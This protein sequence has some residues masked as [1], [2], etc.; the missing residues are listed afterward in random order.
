MFTRRFYFQ[1][2]RE[3]M[4]THPGHLASVLVEYLI[5]FW[6]G[7]RFRN[8]G[9]LLPSLC[10]S[11]CWRTDFDDHG[12]PP[13]PLASSLAYRVSRAVNVAC[14]SANPSTDFLRIR[15]LLFLG[16]LVP[17]IAVGPWGRSPP[18]R[19]CTATNSRYTRGVGDT[20]N[21]KAI[22]AFLLTPAIPAHGWH[23]TVGGRLVRN[24]RVDDRVLTL[25]VGVSASR[26]RTSRFGA[27]RFGAMR[28]GASRFGAMGACALRACALRACALRAVARCIWE[29]GLV[30]HR[31]SAVGLQMADGTRRGG[32]RAGWHAQRET[33]G[34]EEHDHCEREVVTDHATSLHAA[35]FVFSTFQNESGGEKRRENTE[36]V[37]S[38][39]GGPSADGSH[40]VDYRWRHSWR[41]KTMLKATPL[42]P[43]LVHEL[44]PPPLN[45]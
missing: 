26:F 8:D 17:E 19:G 22:N 16:S 24:A 41:L 29:H 39:L 5:F 33:N 28:T 3:Q 32:R 7:S 13:R 42:G 11:S 23:W 36:Q 43:S 25:F 30:R 2:R 21:D 37:T 35:C 10:L 18:G 45:A 9:H 4:T 14:A 6:Q 15:F 1:G 31:L 27:S 38:K 12:S 34:E 44:S 40:H 20:R